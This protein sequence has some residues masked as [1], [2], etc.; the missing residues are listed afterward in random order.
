MTQN[1]YKPPFV[2]AEIG[3]NHKGE[4]EIAKELIK[5]AKIFCNA[6]AVKFQKR[7]NKELL[8]E[9]QYN[10]PHPNPV[11]SYGDTYGAHREFLEFSVE[12]HQELKDFCEE[13][14]IVYSTSVWDTTSAKEIASLNPEFIKIPSAC[15]NHYEMLEWLCENY[16]GEIH[17]S[18]GMT[19][20]D[21]IEDLITF[22]TEKGRNKDLVVYNCTSGY[23]VPFEDVCLL[24]ITLLIEKYA[25][26]VKHIGFSGHH[27]GI[28]VDIAA[29][30]LGANII[31]RHYTIDRTWK[32]TDH[33]ASLEPMGL[34]KLKRD[35]TAVHKALSFK[36]T[37]ILAIEQVQ[38]DKLK[39]RK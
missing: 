26:K 17:I 10:A 7:H 3:C 13:I 32:G 37:D 2:I 21:E 30:T 9:E 34:R 18:T 29:Y 4:M 24:D 23:P 11:N 6:D 15:N 20:K 8:T 36:N 27:L 19:S 38:R 39:Y 1:T 16:S 25:D 12:Q 5:V 22:F 28:A 33:A 14:G 35:L 31:E